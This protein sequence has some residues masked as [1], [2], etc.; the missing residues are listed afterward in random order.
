LS[1]KEWES[2]D[3]F[4]INESSGMIV[5]TTFEVKDLVRETRYN[6]KGTRVIQLSRGSGSWKITD[7]HTLWDEDF[8][9]YVYV[10][11]GNIKTDAE[12]EEQREWE[13]LAY[14]PGSKKTQLD[15]YERVCDPLIRS[16]DKMERY[17]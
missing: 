7:D 5:L 8:E 6:R 10:K 17:Y 1:I 3:A 11:F 15:S 13:K 14:R 16:T 12:R 4:L 2:V 9:P